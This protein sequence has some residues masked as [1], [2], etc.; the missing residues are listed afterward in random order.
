MLLRQMVDYLAEWPYLYHFHSLMNC[1]VCSGVEVMSNVRPDSPSLE[2]SAIVTGTIPVE[3]PNDSQPHST[4]T[5]TYRR[6]LV[7]RHLVMTY[8]LLGKL[9]LALA[10]LG[11]DPSCLLLL[12]LFR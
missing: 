3:L 1:L 4:H 5:I 8:L 9:M 12:A 10:L 11:L 2:T 6:C 7:L